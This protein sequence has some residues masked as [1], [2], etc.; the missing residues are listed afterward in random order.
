MWLVLSRLSRLWSYVCVIIVACVVLYRVFC[1]SLCTCVVMCRLS[2][3]LACVESVFSPVILRLRNNWN[4]GLCCIG[5]L[6]CELVLWCVGCLVHELVL[7][8]LC[9]ELELRCVGCLVRLL[10]VVVRLVQVR[11]QWKYN[12]CSTVLVWRWLTRPSTTASLLL[13]YIL[14]SPHQLITVHINKKRTPI[15][16]NSPIPLL[17]GFFA[18]W[19]QLSVLII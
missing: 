13:F 11:W 4:C 6:V 8:R 16:N 9:P 10:A 5:F 3:L 17:H 15:I 1:L 2:R 12:Q 19:L 14:Q 18:E 7:C